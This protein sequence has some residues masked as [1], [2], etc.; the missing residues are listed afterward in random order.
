[1]IGLVLVGASG[2][3]GR[4][5][6]EAAGVTE[7]F[8]IK[9]R[10]DRPRSKNPGPPELTEP[11][12]PGDV[13]VDFSSPEGT[14]AAC[15]LC[16]SAGV[17]LVSGTTGLDTAQEGR[18]TAT[19]RSVAVLTASNFS[20][21]VL[22]LRRAINA[23]LE[24]LPESWDVEIIERHHRLK[25]DAPSGTALTLAREIGAL[26]EIP[27]SGFRHGRSGRSGPRP[28]DE[29][30]IHAVRGGSWVGDH[31]VLLAGAGE[32]LEL[33]HVAQDRGAFAHGVLAA[34]HFV[35]SAPPGMYDLAHLATRGRP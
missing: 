13:V 6:A 11:L 35:S 34:A 5:V 9:G 17:A 30:G 12:A 3:M 1:L 24:A 27:E 29:L 18:V 31:T 16:V 7:G 33:R 4:A 22:A 28:P 14:M 19:A 26:R 21:G 10:I 15:E 8:R 32:W 20:L 25:A 2:R 23:A